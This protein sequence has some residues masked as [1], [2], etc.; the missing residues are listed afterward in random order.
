MGQG[1]KIT[2]A[3]IQMDSFYLNTFEI[4]N[5]RLHTILC[6]SF[7][8]WVHRKFMSAFWSVMSAFFG[9]SVSHANLKIAKSE[10]LSSKKHHQYELSQSF[11]HLL[12]RA[13]IRAFIHSFIN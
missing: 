2:P 7:G 11:F 10:T 3:A 4:A 5:S 6:P 13:F 8:P 9:L 12:H 1:K